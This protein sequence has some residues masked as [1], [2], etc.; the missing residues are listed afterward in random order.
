M[1]AAQRA[2]EKTPTSWWMFRAMARLFLSVGF[3]AKGDLAQA[4]ATLYD[5]GE[6]VYDHA[7]QLRM[8]TNA[9]FIHW[10]SVDLSALQ[11]AAIQIL[12]KA[13]QA[14]FQ[15][16][17]VT[18][19]RYH[20]AICHYQR[21]EL[22]EAEEQLTPLVRQPYRSHVQCYLHS[23]AAMALVYQAQG[24]PDRARDIAQ[25][26]ITFALE[27]DRT[28]GLFMAKA[29]HAELA[30]RQGRLA[31]AVYWA[32]HTDVPLALPMP[33]FY[34]LPLTP[35]RILIAQNT[36]ISRKRAG[37]RLLNLHDYFT[38]IHYTSVVIEVLA[39]QALLHQVEGR[40][41]AALATLGQAIALAEPGG[42]IRPFID[43]GEPLQ[44]LLEA[45]LRE[46]AASPF[47][48]K[49]L[50]AFSQTLPHGAAGRQAN[51]SLLTPLTPRE[52][53]VLALLSKRYT[54]NEIA[55]AL[56][57]SVETVASHLQ[58]IGDKLGVRGRRTIVQVA[59]ELG[60]LE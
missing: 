35:A 12:A 34:R 39:M 11:Q 21:N 51:A 4:N 13:G 10:I 28:N 17:T 5:S 29:F 32:E 25:R 50:A 26:M 33:F 37:Q 40:Q 3:V 14:E 59:R 31:E 22:A 49:I 43:L 6:S 52:L 36:P 45:S 42:S 20:L 44:E 55:E 7:F 41:Q 54:N 56:V 60:L 9:C 24:Q 23:A 53:E 15:V 8:L 16:E 38:S 1:L 19:A 2:L 30:L 46:H 18:W 58:H 48:A 47:E 57:I 27:I